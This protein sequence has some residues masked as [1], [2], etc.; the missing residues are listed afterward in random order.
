MN[1][2]KNIKKFILTHNVIRRHM[3]FFFFLTQTIQNLNRGH[4]KEKL[5]F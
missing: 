2:S 3:S 1:S 4:L 5:G